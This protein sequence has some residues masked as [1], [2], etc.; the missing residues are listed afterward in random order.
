MNIFDNITNTV[1]G[2]MQDMGLINTIRKLEDVRDIPLNNDWYARISDWNNLYAG[3][4]DSIHNVTST[5]IAGTK[6]RNMLSL[7]MPKVMAEEMAKLI[8][9]EDSRIT[10]DNEQ[11]KKYLS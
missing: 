3:H 9:N 7:N 1:K 10:V 5:S 8:F 6:T 11:L 2:V 4:L